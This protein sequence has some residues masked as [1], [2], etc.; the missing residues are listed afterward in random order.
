[1]KILIL[2]LFFISFICAAVEDDDNILTSFNV[3]EKISRV[4]DIKP[5]E[6]LSS[7]R[8]NRSLIERFIE[9]KKKVCSGVFSTKILGE[10]GG[11]GGPAT[12]LSK[13]EKVVCFRELQNI[14]I[15]FINNLYIARKNYLEF[16]HKKRINSLGETRT[17]AIKR[18]RKVF[19]KK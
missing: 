14:Q 18:V 2:T 16:L 15:T 4:K 6:F 7:V 9:Y 17:E 11:I 3:L 5:E 8:D 1:M 13:E 12:T 10:D 19:G